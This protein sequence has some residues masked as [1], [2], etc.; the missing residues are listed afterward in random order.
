MVFGIFDG[1]GIRKFGNSLRTASG[2][3]ME[4]LVDVVRQRLKIAAYFGIYMYLLIE[5]KTDGQNHTKK[6][7]ASTLNSPQYIDN[8]LQ[9]P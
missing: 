9:R 1:H 3:Y 8:L 2:N 7:S 5:K 4:L 6:N